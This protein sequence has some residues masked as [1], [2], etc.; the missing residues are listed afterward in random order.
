MAMMT[1]GRA[2]V[3]LVPLDARAVGMSVA[4]TNFMRRPASEPARVGHREWLHFS[5]GGPDLTLLVNM[6]VVDDQRPSVPRGCER[7]RVLVL[8]RD[9]GGWGGGADEVGAAELEVHGGRVF[10][11]LAESSVDLVAGVFV[12]K[13]RLRDRPIAFELE[14]RPRAFPSMAS[15]VAIGPGE[16]PINWVV[17]PD[18]SADGWLEIAGARRQIRGAPAYHDHNWGYFSHRDF[19]WQWGHALPDDGASPFSAVF[20]RLLNGAQTET[21]MQSR[22]LWRDGRQYRVFR[23][24]EVEV[25]AEGLLRKDDFFTVPRTAR[26]LTGGTA[27]DIPKRLRIEAKGRGDAVSACFEAIDA[28]R[29]AVPNEHDL[30]T[31]LIH[32]VVGVFELRGVVRGE[33]VALGGHAVFEYLGRGA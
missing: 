9:S 20:A 16:E 18:L 6:S 28:A 2:P 19:A 15:N 27:A 12:V 26:L 8:V 1:T 22:R 33:P 14:L 17:V 31:T 21:Y 32:E 30:G 29:I 11:A 5:I 13:V 4:R 10:V 3:P 7:G 23:E 24:D 25:S